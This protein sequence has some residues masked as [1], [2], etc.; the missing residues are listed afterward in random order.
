[1]G[2]KTY[3]LK[4]LKLSIE[5]LNIYNEHTNLVKSLEKLLLKSNLN[6]DEE[7]SKSAVIAIFNFSK[8][9]LPKISNITLDYNNDILKISQKHKLD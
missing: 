4:D 6:L 9:T 7:Q 3:K 1:M 2:V 5:A 8:G